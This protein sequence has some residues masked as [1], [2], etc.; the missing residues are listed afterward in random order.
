LNAADR[1]RKQGFRRWY[2]RQLVEGHIYL[3]TAVL[4]LIM[5]AVG[6]ESLGERQTSAELFLYSGLVLGGGALTWIAWRRYAA[7]MIAAEW[8]GGQAVCPG[9][10]NHGFRAVPL[11]EL[12]SE[13]AATPRRQLVAACRKCGHYW[14]IDPGT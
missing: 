3:V 1:I 8:V 13:F 2:E 7:M 11:A 5:L 9:C 12:P 14:Q 10:Q 6:F 4:S